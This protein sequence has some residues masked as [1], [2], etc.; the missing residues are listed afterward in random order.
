[1]GGSYFKSGPPTIYIQNHFPMKDKKHFIWAII[2]VLLGITM[3]YFGLTI[4]YAS[5]GI[6][7]IT[8]I[9]GIGIILS[10]AKNIHLSK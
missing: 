5:V 4:T 9:V 1:M 6:N 3:A 7:I 8:V 2:E 10:G